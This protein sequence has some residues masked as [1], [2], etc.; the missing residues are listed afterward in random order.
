MSGRM[1]TGFVGIMAMVGLVACGDV[2]T[3]TQPEPPA[4]AWTLGAKFGRDLQRGGAWTQHHG[5]RGRGDAALR[6]R[7]A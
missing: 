4:A 1:I 2:Q 5:F 7:R 3:Q 6:R